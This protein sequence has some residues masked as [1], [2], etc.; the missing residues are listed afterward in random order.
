M[1]VVVA[2][3]LASVPSTAQVLSARPASI[4][5]TA[6]VP[7]RPESN[8]LVPAQGS[9]ALLTVT[10]NAIDFETSVGLSSRIATR[11]EVRLSPTWGAESGRVWVRNRRGDLEPLTAGGPAVVVN[12]PNAASALRLRIEGNRA[13]DASSLTIPLEYRMKVGT[14]DEFSVWTLSS[15]LRITPDSTA[16]TSR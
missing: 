11:M 7:P 14:G 9:V 6:V 3:V 13:L 10:R 2:S 5:L 16:A 8:D 1:L 15:L 4:S 12:A